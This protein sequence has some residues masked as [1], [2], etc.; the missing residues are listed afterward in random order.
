MTVFDDMIPDLL[1]NIKLNPVVT[2][3]FVLFLLYNH[4]LPHQKILD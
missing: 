1:S 2:E 4:F 3:T